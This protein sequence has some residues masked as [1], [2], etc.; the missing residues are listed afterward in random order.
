M[1]I[2][3]LGM[4]L[5]PSLGWRWMI[6]VSIAPSVILIFLFKVGVSVLVLRRS[7]PD[8]SLRS[9]PVYSRIGSLQRVRW[10]RSC[11]R[12]DA[13]EDRSH[14]PVF[15]PSWPPG[16]AAPGGFLLRFLLRF[17]RVGGTVVVLVG[18]AAKVLVCP[19]AASRGRGGTGGSC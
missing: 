5:V 10:K 14:E 12:G 1:L 16:G 13:A 8:P 18:G 3:L 19:S 4:L 9:K 15:T 11:C 17:L 2:V 7:R 6:R